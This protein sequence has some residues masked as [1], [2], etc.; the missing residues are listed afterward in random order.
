[1]TTWCWVGVVE[2]AD[3][4]WSVRVGLTVFVGAAT[5]TIFGSE[6]STALP[7]VVL[8][9]TAR[10]GLVVSLGRAVFTVEI[11]AGA[12]EERLR[13][14]LLAC[15]GCSGVLTGSGRARAQAGRRPDRPGCGWCFGVPGAPRLRGAHVLLLVLVL[16]RR[17]D[18]AAVVGAGLAT[19]WPGWGLSYRRGVGS[20]AGAWLVAALC[21][22]RGG[23]PGGVRLV[24]VGRWSRIRCCRAGLVGVGDAVAVIVAVAVAGAVAGAVR[25]RRGGAVGGGGDALRW[26]VAGAGLAVGQHEFVLTR[27]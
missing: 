25:D 4:V 24:G 20:A 15:P 22:W 2:G 21:L 7:L 10:E 9:R 11:D 6:Y 19:K 23:G 16:A 13:S 8:G 18:T 14:G 27:R 3:G 12:V 17:A 5:V 26:A 1:M